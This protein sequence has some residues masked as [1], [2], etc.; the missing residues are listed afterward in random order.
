MAYLLDTNTIIRH[1][2]EA[3]GPIERRLYAL[4]QEDVRLCSVVKAELWHGSYKYGRMDLRQAALKK[5]F[6]RYESL[7]FDDFAA[8]EYGR[9]RHELEAKGEIIGPNDLKIAAIALYHDLTVVT[10][11]TNEFCRV[12]GLKVEDWS[13]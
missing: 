6:I 4:P 10:T 8:L 2:K 13:V 5:L 1:I 3:G 7:S 11:N 9:I 12:A